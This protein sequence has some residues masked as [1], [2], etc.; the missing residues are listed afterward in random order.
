[1][2]VLF[3]VLVLLAS[4]L[5]AYTLLFQEATFNIGRSLSQFKDLS[6]QD[7][8]TPRNQTVRNLLFPALLIILF[9][10]TAAIYG[11]LAAI[12]TVAFC[13]LVLIPAIKLFLPKPTDVHY[14]RA[15]I[16]SLAEYH[17]SFV[18]RL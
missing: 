18:H 17:D 5:G 14:R 3:F 2:K 9:C 1:M 6:L 10:L 8:I 11:W 12:G 4:A 13:F 15:I 7:A 16:L